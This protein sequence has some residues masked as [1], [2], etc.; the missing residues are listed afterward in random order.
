MKTPNTSILK[1]QRLTKLE[2]SQFSLSADLKAILFGLLLGDLCAKKK[3][4]V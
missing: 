4:E 3:T 2:R 1:V